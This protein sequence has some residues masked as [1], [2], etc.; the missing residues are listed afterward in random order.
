MSLVNILR[1]KDP[2]AVSNSERS[3]ALLD[4]NVQINNQGF[5][6]S[7]IPSPRRIPRCQQSS[8]LCPSIPIQLR[9]SSRIGLG[10]RSC[11]E[12]W[13]SSCGHQQGQ[14]LGVGG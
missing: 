11:R 13:N 3:H 2:T 4:S 8:R 1:L 5:G 14:S 10:P 12:H 6:V 7:H 9:P